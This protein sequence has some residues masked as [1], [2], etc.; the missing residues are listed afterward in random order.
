MYLLILLCWCIKLSLIQVLLHRFYLIEVCRPGFQERKGKQM[1]N[2]ECKQIRRRNEVT[3]NIFAL[4][5][6]AAIFVVIIALF[7]R[8]NHY[9][10]RVMSRS[11]IVKFEQSNENAYASIKE[12]FAEKIE[13]R[14]GRKPEKMGLWVT[15]LGYGAYHIGVYYRYNRVW[16]RFDIDNRHKLMTQE[17]LTWAENLFPY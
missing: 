15:N 8:C 1:Y 3:M 9:G 13:E 14:T 2:Y 10:Y 11:E 5:V 4:I 17:V 12:Y 6:I 16:Y 7:I